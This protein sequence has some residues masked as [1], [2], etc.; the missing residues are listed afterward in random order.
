MLGK[1]V[2][3]LEGGSHCVQANHFAIVLRHYYF[4]LVKQSPWF[5]FPTRV[6]SLP[7]WCSRFA[8]GLVAFLLVAA[9]VRAGVVINEIFYHAP[10]DLDN[11]QFIEL[12][13]PA[14]QP[15]DIAGWKL[16]KAVQYQF[17]AQ[18]TIPAGGYLVLCKDMKEF[19]K[20]YGFDAAGQF[21]GSL[22]HGS[23]HI[24]LADA[25]GKKIDSVKYKSRTPWPVAADG[26]SSSLER[27]CPTAAETGPENWAASPLAPGTPKPAGTPGKKNA[28][29]AAHLPPAI[30]NVTFEPS[31]AGP[32]QEITVL[33]NVSSKDEVRAVELRYRLAG[34]GYEKPEQTVRMTKTTKNQFKGII[35]AQKGG[36]DRS[37]PHRG[38]GCEGGPAFLPE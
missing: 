20:H 29:Y 8:A 16:A 2:G 28:N 1:L 3:V 35:P 38:Y 36:P 19:K 11:L 5:L 27:I 4:L 15:V 14:A 12:H 13:N 23:D 21:A 33:A 25:K 17:P 31:Q 32:D 34:S 26:Y 6:R 7:M 37:L 18:T 9:P 30:T 10:D 22:S 24:E